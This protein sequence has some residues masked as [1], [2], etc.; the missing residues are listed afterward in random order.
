[1]PLFRVAE[2]SGTIWTTG[3]EQQSKLTP[4]GR[5]I[6]ARRLSVDAWDTVINAQARAAMVR[7]ARRLMDDE[8]YLASLTVK[9][10]LPPALQALEQA[11]LVLQLA[12]ESAVEMSELAH[13]VD[14]RIGGENGRVIESATSPGSRKVRCLADPGLPPRPRSSRKLWRHV[15]GR[16]LLLK[17]SCLFGSHLPTPSI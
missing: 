4:D 17:L 11:L 13:P 15:C 14:G 12:A 2:G 8:D 1:M 3:V 9:M 10:T 16:T 7:L 5:P 6:L